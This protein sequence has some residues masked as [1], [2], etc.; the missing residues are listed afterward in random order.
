MSEVISFRLSRDNSREAQALETLRAWR[1]EGYSVRHILTE[2]LIQ[3]SDL[4][5]EQTAAT[6]DELRTTLGQ[7]SQLLEQFG[8][9]NPAQVKKLGAQPENSGLTDGFNASVTKSARLGMKLG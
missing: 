9:G 7:V 4:K 8:N 6:M 3:L 2:A 1:V 5:S